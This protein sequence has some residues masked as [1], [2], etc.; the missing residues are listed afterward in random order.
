MRIWM[1]MVI[2]LLIV[3][4]LA[5]CSTTIEE[6]TGEGLRVAKEIFQSEPI[7]PNDQVENVEFYVP[8]GFSI[9][10]DSDKTNIILQEKSNSYVLFINPNEKQD[11]HLY[12]DLIQAKKK[13]VILAEKTFEQDSRFGFI[14]VLPSGEEQ[15]KIVVSIGGVKMTTI[16]DQS[17]I[18]TTIEKMMKIVRSVKVEA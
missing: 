14:I 6:Q 10:E 13:D 4:S 3:I 11:S 12:Y 9:Q 5:A 17:D 15:Y 8:R 2:T 1:R 18:Y 7:E 16:V